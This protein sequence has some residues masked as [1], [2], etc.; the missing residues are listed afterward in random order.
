MIKAPSL[1]YFYATIEKDII[2]AQSYTEI[3]ELAFLIK[4]CRLKPYHYVFE[5]KESK[6]TLYR[7]WFDEFGNSFTIEQDKTISIL[8]NDL[9]LDCQKIISTD[10]YYGLTINKVA[11]MSK[12]MHFIVG[13]DEDLFQECYLLT[14]LGLD[15]YFRSY[16]YLYGEW[17]QVSPL[18]LGM[19]NLLNIVSQRNLQEY[20]Q[21]QRKI[22]LSCLPC[23]AAE[24]WLSSLEP[25]SEQFSEIL[26]QRYE[27]IHEVIK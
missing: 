4:A 15:N 22:D 7:F 17:Q 3:K 1:E 10:L 25:K 26:K 2:L 9:S 20:R 13:K 16:L 19:K 12:L 14:F 21:M 5:E 8:H 24:W 11:K 23:Q 18:L 27:T 6:I